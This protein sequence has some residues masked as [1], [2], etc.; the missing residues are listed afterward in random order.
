MCELY[1]IVNI[2]Q[3]SNYGLSIWTKYYLFRKVENA[4]HKDLGLA[5]CDQIK[6]ECSFLM[7]SLRKA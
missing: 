6:T 7:C 1:T 4:Q 3:T 5:L 2:F